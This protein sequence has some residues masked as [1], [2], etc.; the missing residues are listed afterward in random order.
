MGL[1]VKVDG[2]GNIRARWQGKDPEKPS[3]MIGSHLDTVLHGGKFDGVLGV[4][5]ALGVVRVLNEQQVRLEVPVEIIVFA[6]EEGS[7]FGSVCAGSKALTG[8]YSIQDLKRIKN[9]EGLSMYQAAEKFGLKPER[10]SREL[11]RPDEVQAMLELHIEQGGVLDSLKI[12]I[13]IVEA[14]AGSKW[15]RVEIEG[16]PNHAGATPMGMRKDPMTA[17][18]QIIAEIDKIVREKAFATTVGTVGK[19]DCQPNIP[20]CIPEKVIFIVDLRDVILW[21]LLLLRGRLRQGSKK[22]RLPMKCGL[23][24]KLWANPMLLGCLTE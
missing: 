13:G 18:A 1:Q 14:I 19:F 4:V 16:I 15:L 3:I 11:L 12:P 7:N 6:E 20:N 8:R 23:L 2:V 24:L 5:A 17:A 21:V 10:L 9:P 22:L